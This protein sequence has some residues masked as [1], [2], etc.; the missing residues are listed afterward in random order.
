MCAALR[1]LHSRR[2]LHRV[3]IVCRPVAAPT[4]YREVSGSSA[5]KSMPVPIMLSQKPDFEYCR[6]SNPRTYS[7]PRRTTSEWVTSD[8]PSS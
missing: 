3:S 2:I 8:V 6:I 7:S 1:D 4:A 5:Q